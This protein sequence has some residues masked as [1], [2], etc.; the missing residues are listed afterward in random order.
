MRTYFDHEKLDVYQLEL[1]F[2]TWV[3]ALL[4]KIRQRSTDAQIAEVSDQLD[5][6]SLSALLNR[7]KETA[8]ASDEREQ[9][10]S[11][12]RAVRRLN[13]QRVWMR[14]LQRAFAA[15]ERP[16]KASSCSCGSLRC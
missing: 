4:V 15:A 1:R 16:M 9:S 11:M 14:W 12:T 3:T 10:S 13:A 2:I 8:D 6:A 7:P 5:R